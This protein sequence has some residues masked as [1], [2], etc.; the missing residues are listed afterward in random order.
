MLARVVGLLLLAVTGELSLAHAQSS[1]YKGT[2]VDNRGRT[3]G[4]MDGTDGDTI[5]IGRVSIRLHG[6][7]APE[8]GRMCGLAPGKPPVDCGRASAQALRNVL[9]RRAHCI[10][11][12]KADNN[13]RPIAKCSP[14]RKKSLDAGAEMVRL[15][16]ACAYTKYSRD[17]VKLE[18]EAR[19]NRRGIWAVPDAPRICDPDRK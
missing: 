16:W 9:T 1:I 7:D 15:G 11:T 19:R 12:G 6:I 3:H 4:A 17:Y 5:V 8:L 14:G 13:R 2:F 18:D 10:G